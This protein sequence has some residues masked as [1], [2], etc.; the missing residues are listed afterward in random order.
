[1]LSFLAN[2]V[3]NF[4]FRAKALRRRVANCFFGRAE[5]A[6]PTDQPQIKPLAAGAFAL[7][8]WERA[9]VKAPHNKSKMLS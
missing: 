6:T 4:A 9:G 1:M 2:F 3:A 7:S 8:L 5:G